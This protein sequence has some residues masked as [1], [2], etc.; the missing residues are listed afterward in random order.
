MYTVCPNC[1]KQFHIYAEHIAA[2]GGQVRCGFCSQQ[3]NALE[4]LSDEP[5]PENSI[6]D[7]I[8]TTTASEDVLIANDSSDNQ[9]ELQTAIDEI[10]V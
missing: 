4:R 6:P 9:E 7:E 3:F 8:V 10:G 2:A 5:L 1:A